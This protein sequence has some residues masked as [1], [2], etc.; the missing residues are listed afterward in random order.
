MGERRHW[1]TAGAE[2]FNPVTPFLQ[3]CRNVL[4]FNFGTS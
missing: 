1:I 4:R 2:N 3:G